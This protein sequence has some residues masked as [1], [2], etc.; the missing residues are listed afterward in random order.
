[1]TP[2]GES[3]P[4]GQDRRNSVSGVRGASARAAY[5]TVDAH[6]RRELRE[7]LWERKN[8]TAAGPN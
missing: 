3:T 4:G 2:Q 8:R 1:M 6:D 7:V 5:S